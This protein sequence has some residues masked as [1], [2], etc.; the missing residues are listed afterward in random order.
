[1]EQFTLTTFDFSPWEP[2]YI[3]FILLFSILLVLVALFYVFKHL[4]FKKL[5]PSITLRKF[6][7][8]AVLLIIAMF[9]LYGSYF[10]FYHMQVKP[11]Y[12]ETFN[13]G[14]YTAAPDVSYST[15][16]EMILLALIFHS[17][18]FLDFLLFTFL[19]KKQEKKENQSTKGKAVRE[20]P[21]L[22]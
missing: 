7:K 16:L 3:A 21:S 2:R 9:I 4:L 12:E 22:T 5:P 1:M 10:L 14:T 6:R 20:L 15:T 19:I 8:L 17:F 11:Y 18:P 13:D